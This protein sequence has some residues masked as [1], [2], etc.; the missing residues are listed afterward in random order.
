[1]EALAALSLPHPHPHPT[2]GECVASHDKR[3][4][5]SA[6]PEFKCRSESC[7]CQQ[8]AWLLCA[9]LPR[10]VSPYFPGVVMGMKARYLRG[11][12]GGGCMAHSRCSTDATCSQEVAV[13]MGG[14]LATLLPTLVAD[15]GPGLRNSVSK[16]RPNPPFLPRTPCGL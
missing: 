1:M 12:M 11:T 14:R 15:K 9:C 8:A 3:T 7:D 6:R 10:R 2:N 5:S 13:N 4:G 16:V